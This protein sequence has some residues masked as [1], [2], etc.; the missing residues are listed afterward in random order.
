VIPLIRNFGED[1]E[2]RIA[3]I[4]NESDDPTLDLEEY[5]GDVADPTAFD[6]L[7]VTTGS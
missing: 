7:E 1:G 4:L 2:G 3:Q 6:S 5:D